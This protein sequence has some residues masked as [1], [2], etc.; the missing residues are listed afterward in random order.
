VAEEFDLEASGLLDGLEGKA[1]A[2][3]AELIPWLLDQGVS[4]AQIR[5]GASLQLHPLCG[6][7]PP[8]LAWPYLERAAVATARARGE[9]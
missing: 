2:E 5:G 6:G 4:V 1:R 3:R 9:G 8:D 7:M